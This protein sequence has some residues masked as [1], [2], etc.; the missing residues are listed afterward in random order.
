MQDTYRKKTQEVDLTSIV[1]LERYLERVINEHNDKLKG[2]KSQV[3]TLIIDKSY[4]KKE[5]DVQCN[6]KKPKSE[7]ENMRGQSSCVQSA[8]RGL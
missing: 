6:L 3:S 4:D 7:Y 8:G 1:A 2:M 5:I